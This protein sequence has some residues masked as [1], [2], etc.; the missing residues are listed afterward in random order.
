MLK[1]LLVARTLLGGGHRYERSKDAISGTI[2]S[3]VDHTESQTEMDRSRLGVVQMEAFCA[4]HL[5]RTGLRRLRM[6]TT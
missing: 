2:S 5:Y 6:A 3:A 1:E 4:S